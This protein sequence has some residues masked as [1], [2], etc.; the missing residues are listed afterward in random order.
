MLTIIA[1]HPGIQVYRALASNFEEAEVYFKRPQPKPYGNGESVSKYFIALNA[2][3]AFLDI[4][5]TEHWKIIKDDPIFA[6]FP[7]EFET[8]PVDEV[9]KVLNRPD[10]EESDEVMQGIKADSP[11]YLNEEKLV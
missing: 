7:A 10:L 3:A 8:V 5:Q 9:L 1:W 2:H 11:D 4:R 6:E